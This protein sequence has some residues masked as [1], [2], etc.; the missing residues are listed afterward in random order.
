[1][2]SAQRTEQC[3][4]LLEAGHSQRFV[5]RVLH[6][7]RDKVRAIANGQECPGA[8]KTRGRPAKIS[9]EVRIFVEA[10]LRADATISD[11]KMVSLVQVRFGL[12]IHRTSIC[13]LRRELRYFYRPPKVIQSLT[14]EQRGARIEFCRWVLEN[15]D[16][17]PNLIFSDESRFEI[18]PDNTWRRIKRG[19]LNETCFAARNKHNR[20]LM[21]WGA[22]G[23]GGYKSRL[24]RCS[25]GEDSREYI[26]ILGKSEMLPNLDDK[27]GRSGWTFVQDGAPCHQSREALAWLADHHVVVAP[28]WPPNSPDLNPIEMVW[29]VMKRTLRQLEPDGNDL[30]AQLQAVW[31]A[32]SKDTIDRLVSSF[33]SRCQQ[34][35]DVRGESIT[36]YLSGHRAPPTPDD[37][38]PPS[39]WTDRDDAYLMQLYETH[40]AKWTLI[41]R[42]MGRRPMAVKN[43]YRRNAQI[44]IN[45]HLVHLAHLPTIDTFEFDLPDVETLD[46]FLDRFK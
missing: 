12:T 34:V 15:Q 37:D 20:G 10:N 17:I 31:G 38:L 27:F 3:Q 5:A 21:V 32:I 43:R 28:G 1:M 11:D 46:D 39:Q 25:D 26:D 22:I 8:G 16:K 7:G 42:I 29:G 30:F 9:Q 13:R 4:A 14:Q 35:L 36:P 41:G 18:G 45:E 19:V 2:S 40:G 6:I 24:V 33:Q 44:A 23:P